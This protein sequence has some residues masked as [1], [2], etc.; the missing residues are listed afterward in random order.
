VKEL[1]LGY[2]PCP[3]DT[4]IFYALSHGLI[5]VPYRF[6]TL[7]ADVEMLNQQIKE[8]VLDISKL[9]AHA[10]LHMLDKYW[11][12]RS[13]GAI[14]RGCGPL[15]VSRRF[16]KIQELRD[17]VIA[18]DRTPPASP[19]RGSPGAMRSDDLRQDHAGRCLGG[20]RC[21]ADNP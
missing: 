10:V 5:R 7:L 19:E 16:S 2:S 6:K 12:L 8:G 18:H 17:A 4:H 3:N 20:S 13:G 9:S 14:G 1:T 15:V 11:L 21:R